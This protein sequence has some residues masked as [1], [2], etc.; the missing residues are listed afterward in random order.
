MVD[1]EQVKRA[2]DF[3]TGITVVDLLSGDAGECG[4]GE[5][6]L[7]GMVAGGTACCCVAVCWVGV[8]W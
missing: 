6:E 7:G 5:E 1:I 4:L 2:L 3:F 8:V